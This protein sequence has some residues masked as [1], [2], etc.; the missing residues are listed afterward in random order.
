E[1]LERAVAGLAADGVP[2][3]LARTAAGLPHL[4]AACDI[5]AVAENGSDESPQAQGRLLAV[6]RVH[7]SLAA[8][9]DLAWLE[10]A[11]DRAPRRSGWDRLALTQLADELAGILRGLTRNAVAADCGSNP[12]GVEAWA[13]ANLR[14]L[15]RYRALVAELR[16][17]P[18]AD[19]AMLSVAVRT[20]G[21]LL[22][23]R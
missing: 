5:V 22:R 3:E 21:E 14:G 18:E 9:L 19:L 8:L 1:A 12:A 7:F 10:A 15:D 11:I 23:G 17:A 13:R 6:A 4:L 20:L 2:P 16:A